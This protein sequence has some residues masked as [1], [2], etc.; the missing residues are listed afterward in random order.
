MVMSR[1]HSA[2]EGGLARPGCGSV[3]NIVHQHHEVALLNFNEDGRYRGIFNK[4]CQTQTGEGCQPKH[5]RRFDGAL[6]L[7]G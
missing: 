3:T 5:D 2:V 6:S 4:R 1:F 7:P